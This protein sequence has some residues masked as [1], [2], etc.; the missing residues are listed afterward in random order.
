MK[1]QPKK[2]F[3]GLEVVAFIVVFCGLYSVLGTERLFILTGVYFL[4][5]LIP[6]GIMMLLILII[7]GVWFFKIAKSSFIKNPYIKTAI[8]CVI[9]I[10]KLV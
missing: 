10:Q 4:W 7:N 8:S 2:V 3:V 5:P 6:F 1:E 9:L